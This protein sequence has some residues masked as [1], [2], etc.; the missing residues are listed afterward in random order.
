MRELHAHARV[1]RLI[2]AAAERLGLDLTGITVLTETASGPFVMTPLIAA[3]AGGS[4]IAVTRDS[5][6]GSAEEVRAYTAAWATRLSVADAVEVH[7]GSGHDRAPEADLV[8]NLGF[9]R[10]IDARFV[11]RA[12]SGAVSPLSAVMASFGPI[13]LTVMSFSKRVLSLG[14]RNPKSEKA[15]SRTWVWM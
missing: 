7:V 8:T 15:S 12:R 6:Y 14:V 1:E 4:V 2:D 10:P 13:P 11:C 3:R 5:S 9:V